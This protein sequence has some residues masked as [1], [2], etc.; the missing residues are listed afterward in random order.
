MEPP[1]TRV[2][3]KCGQEKNIEEYRVHTKYKNSEIKQRRGTCIEC[4]RESCRIRNVKRYNNDLQHRNS[5]KKYQIEKARENGVIPLAEYRAKVSCGL[6]RKE[7]S[8]KWRINNP[9]KVKIIQKNQY[10]KRK[11]NGTSA[12]AGRK[13]RAKKKNDPI[14]NAKTKEYFKNVQ[15]QR[16]ENLHDL[17]VRQVLILDTDLKHSDIPQELVEIKRKQL[18]LYRE[19]KQIT[20]T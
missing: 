19:T 7:Q 20:N 5:V 10:L 3:K 12:L 13:Y 2:C 6:S 1:V 14:R 17:Y 16:R 8:K 4:D 11:E 15:K 18:K 9:E